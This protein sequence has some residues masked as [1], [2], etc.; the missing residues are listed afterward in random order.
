[1]RILEGRPGA[2]GVAI[3]R[4]ISIGGE[5]DEVYRFPLPADQ[6]EREIE[7]L[8]AARRQAVHD[9]EAT[10]DRAASELGRDLAAIFEAHLLV[11]DDPQFLGTIE[12]QIRTELVNAEW[13]VD[14]TSEALQARFAQVEVD[15]LR[16]RGEDVRDVARHLIRALAGIAHHE[17][18]ELGGEAVI[19]AY[20]LTPSEAVRLGRERVIAFALERG[21]VTSHTTIIARSLNIPL[22]AGLAGISDA[23]T[24]ADRVIV[25]GT[26]GRFIL[27]PTPEMV[28]EYEGIRHQREER[29]GELETIRT[30]PSVTRDGVTID[31]LA[32]IDLPEE[33]DDAVRCGAQG[34][35]LYRSEFLFIERSP[36]LP[37]EQDHVDTYR[38][39]L[40]VIRPHPVVV[41]TFDLGGRKLARDVLETH[42]ENPVLGLRGIR[43]T[44]AR[45]DIFRRQIRA[46]CRA[47]A[48]GD[49]RIML[50][51]VS[52]LDEVHHFK[53]LFREVVAELEAEGLEHNPNLKIGVMIEVPSAAMI[54]DSLAREVD[55]FS[56][57]T[58]DLI[59]YSMAVDRSNEQVSYLYRPVHPGI[60]RMIRFAVRSAE[61]AGIPVSLC[62]E[63][64]ADPQFTPLLAAMG[65]RAF[66]VTPRVIPELKNVI[67]GF[68]LS[69]WAEARDVCLA[70]PTADDVDRYLASH[71]V[72][73]SAA[74][75]SGGD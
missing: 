41:R 24:D 7:R 60:L 58:N 27:H 70:L 66:S 30:L 3:G 35:G 44:L 17:I 13:A 67:R 62:G 59:Q 73:R 61:E 18:S 40:D 15:Y 11:L 75:T 74:P 65:L 50:P 56:I 53:T 63:M 1:M 19:V 21:G 32:N 64:A 12:R 33:I 2:P 42:E 10:R 43:L 45:P 5:R 4:A 72:E 22:V 55:F 48:F 26:G 57:G 54:A 71:A 51:L 39:L 38:R 36:E 34:V 31:L 52:A 8:H 37:S 16:A 9:L 29:E 6:I 46:L 23:V 25:D 49:L 28:V 69:D 20:D 68:A 14:Q 47:G